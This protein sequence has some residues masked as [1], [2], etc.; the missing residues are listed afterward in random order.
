MEKEKSD[1]YSKEILLYFSKSN[2]PINIFIIF[3]SKFDLINS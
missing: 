1:I 3:V 2:I